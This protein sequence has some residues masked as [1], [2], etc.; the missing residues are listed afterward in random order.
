MELKMEWRPLGVSGGRPGE[1]L[2]TRWEL[3]GRL[4][5]VCDIVEG[6]R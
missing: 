6:L 3:T 4:D 5:E 1:L 2:E